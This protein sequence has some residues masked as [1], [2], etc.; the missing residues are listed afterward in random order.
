MQSTFLALITLLLA[1]V[2]LLAGEAASA[3][4]PTPERK[5]ELQ[6]LLVHDCGSC[7]GMQMKGGLGPPLLP[8]NLD[9]KDD[10]VLAWIVLN[11]LPGTAMPPWRG[12]LDDTDAAWLIHILKSNDDEQSTQRDP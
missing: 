7:H 10:A 4:Q 12:L 1:G 2:P 5:Q 8:Q 3:V 9:G 11:G 6:Y